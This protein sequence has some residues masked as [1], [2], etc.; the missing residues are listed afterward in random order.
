MFYLKRNLSSLYLVAISST[1]LLLSNNIY[2]AKSLSKDQIE[3]GFIYNFASFTTWPKNANEQLE[4]CKYKASELDSTLK[5][6]QG[7]KLG[8]KTLN[9]KTIEPGESFT[10]C[11]IV[12][13]QK[14]TDDELK[15]ILAFLN[16]HAILTIADFPGAAEKG[17]MLNMVIRDKKLTFEAN[18]ASARAS[19]VKISSRLL[20]LA[21]EVIQ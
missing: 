21:I 2:A 1:L 14:S 19:G 13:I 5:S 15:A 17:V 8:Q 4:L 12:F 18:L 10:N 3:T 20:T 7:K 9:L 16:G 6:L 11:H